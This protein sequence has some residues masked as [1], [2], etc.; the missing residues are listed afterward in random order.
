M[1]KDKIKG[2]IIQDGI[3]TPDNPAEIRCLMVNDEAEKYINELQQEINQLKKRNKEIYDGFMATTQELTEYAE[4]NEKLKRENN[5]LKADIE[6]SQE[7]ISDYK[8]EEERY[9]LIIKALEKHFTDLEYYEDNE[10]LRQLLSVTDN[11]MVWLKRMAG[12]ENKQ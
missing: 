1:S 12:E 11:D 4:E 8:K 5:L 9:K 10:F 3:P 2:M 6:A 7:I